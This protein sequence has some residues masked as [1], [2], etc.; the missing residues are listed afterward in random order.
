MILSNTE[1]EEHSRKK[2]AL[3]NSRGLDFLPIR[4]KCLQNS[5]CCQK[6][7][8]QTEDG[9]LGKMLAWAYTPS[10]SE[11]EA[12][13]VYREFDSWVFGK[14]SFGNEFCRIWVHLFVVRNSPVYV[15]HDESPNYPLIASRVSPRVCNDC[16]A[17][18]ESESCESSIG[19][20]GEVEG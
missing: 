6:S 11:C 14:E 1:P 13:W 3:E 4:I 16:G 20:S 9:G 5:G 2:L 7:C 10:V 18:R 12:A 8:N 19:L 15:I 17:F